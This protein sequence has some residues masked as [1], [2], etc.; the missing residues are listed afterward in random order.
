MSKV[1]PVAGD[2]MD[3]RSNRALCDAFRSLL[4]TDFYITHLDGHNRAPHNGHAHRL[5]LT[6]TKPWRNE[7]WKAFTELE[8]RLCPTDRDG[9]PR[10]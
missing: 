6:Q 3:A 1:W 5:V 4:T 8:R 9:G 7:V 10:R 2:N